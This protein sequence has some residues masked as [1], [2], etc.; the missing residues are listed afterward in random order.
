MQTFTYEPQPDGVSLQTL[1][2]EEL[3]DGRTRLVA[4][5]L[6]SSFE[7]RASWKGSLIRM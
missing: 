7:D 5:S 3:G 6:C 1:L 4:E 2:F